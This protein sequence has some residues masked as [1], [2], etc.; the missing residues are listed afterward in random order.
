MLRIIELL[1]LLA[2]VAAG[3]LLVR[4]RRRS[5]AAFGWGIAGCVVA[6]L[7]SGIGV[8]GERASL[9]TALGS[10]GGMAGVLEQMGS[11]AWLRFLFLVVAVALLVVA[12]LVDRPDRSRPMGWILGGLVF[13][14][15]GV[16]TR[17]VDIPIEGHEGLT[18]VVELL[19][20]A[21]EAALL[22]LG[23]LLLAVAAVAHRAPADSQP[24]PTELA[25]R[26]GMAAWR[27]YSTYRGSRYR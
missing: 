16:V 2:P 15:L 22:G 6:A 4:Y 5:R 13:G 25:R 10:G 18:V 23:V 20:E 26:A 27:L 17:A 8:I 14:V 9:A 1:G 3:V 7:A 21:V 11:W 12:A 24:E 19:M